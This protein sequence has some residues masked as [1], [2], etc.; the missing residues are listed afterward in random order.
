MSVLPV[1]V[2]GSE[3]G[4]VPTFTRPPGKL[5]TPSRC[6]QAEVE[7]RKDLFIYFTLSLYFLNVSL[8]ES[9]P[10]ILSI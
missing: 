5:Q 7:A 9:H 3:Q 10:F 2:W 6:G 1:D 4:H 8:Q